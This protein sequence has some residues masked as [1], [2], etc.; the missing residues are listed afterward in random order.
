[1]N[2]GLRYLVDPFIT[3]SPHSHTVHPW[4]HR[5]SHQRLA[6]P[7][8]RGISFPDA[9]PR[10]SPTFHTCEGD[11]LQLTTGGFHYI[12]TLFFI[13]TSAN[14]A[15][16]LNQIYTLLAPGGTW[17]NLGPLLWAG[18]GTVG[19]ELSLEEV[20]QLAKQVGFAVETSGEGPRRARTIPC[21]YTQDPEAMFQRVYKAEF[22]VATKPQ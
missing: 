7:L 14:I 8:F 4:A 1:M 11:F 3:P 13:D 15:A 20:L 17:I 22:W 9:L 19:L 18:G 6:A 2:F 21:E 5:F 16:T 10:L 12:V